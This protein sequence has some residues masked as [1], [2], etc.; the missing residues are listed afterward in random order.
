VKAERL[1]SGVLLFLVG[2]V[3]VNAAVLWQLRGSIFQGYGDFANFYTAGKLVRDGHARELYDQGLQW[4]TQQEFASTVKVRGGPLL[5]VRPP[6]EALLFLPMSYLKYPVACVVWLAIKVL[7]LVAVPF[8]L[9]TAPP[10]PSGAIQGLLCLGFFPIGVDL[11]QGQDSVLLLLILVLSFSLIKRGDDFW[12][13]ACL[14]LGLF[15]FHIVVPVVLVLLLRGKFKVILGCL[16]TALVLGLISLSLVGWE[17]ITG[18]PKYLWELNRVGFAAPGNMPNLRGLIASF[19]AARNSRAVAWFLGIAEGA[20]I[21]FSAHVWRRNSNNGPLSLSAGFSLTI[22]VTVL[23]S[24]YLYSYDMTLLLL[25][26]LLL[27]GGTLR[28]HIPQ[29]WPHRLFVI[30]MVLLFFS[31][32]Y[33]GALFRFGGFSRLAFVTIL[34]CV[35]SLVGLVRTPRS[36]IGA[37]E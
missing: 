33:W 28:G 35:I 6:F 34:L 21:L 30:P 15:K 11:L 14:G 16:S 25:P 7:I 22:A 5:Y 13:G 37:A 12:C 4:R 29:D 2:M 36:L 26:V 9:H 27:G 31:P 3:L 18:Y 17:G 20:G 24:Y 23:T 8:L 19:G 32:I 1:K 10:W